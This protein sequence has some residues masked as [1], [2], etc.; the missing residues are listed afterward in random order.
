[1]GGR[2]E[3]LEHGNWIFLI[4]GG[5]CLVYVMC[6]PSMLFDVSQSMC[7]PDAV[8]G[9]VC[10]NW[11]L[12][13]ITMRLQ[14]SQGLLILQKCYCCVQ[15]QSQKQKVK[16]AKP[17]DPCVC[18]GRTVTREGMKAKGDSFIRMPV[19]I[20]PLPRGSRCPGSGVLRRLFRQ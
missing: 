5:L 20:S 17:N 7:R 14:S 1:M 6:Y 9:R 12:G 4:V 2:C 10:E 3:G 8:A 15:Y 11:R 16:P 13:R 19:Q 18:L